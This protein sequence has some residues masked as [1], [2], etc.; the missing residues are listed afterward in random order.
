M[1][2]NVPDKEILNLCATYGKTVDKKV[3]YEKLNIKK[4]SNL[5]G[6]TRFVDVEMQDGKSFNNNIGWRA[7]FQGTKGSESLCCTTTNRLNVATVYEEL[8]MAVQQQV[9]VKLARKVE[10]LELKCPS[11]WNLLGEPMVTLL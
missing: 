4:G 8:L 10:L 11:I 6:G 1:P 2:L 9:S 5:T 7:P 3:E